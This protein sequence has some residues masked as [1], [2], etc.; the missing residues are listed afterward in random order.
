MNSQSQPVYDPRGAYDGGPYRQP[1]G[2][3]Q[4]PPNFDGGQQQHFDSGLD[5]SRQQLQERVAFLENT[6]HQME[7]RIKEMQNQVWQARNEN[8]QLRN[9]LLWASKR[10][11]EE[12][13]DIQRHLARLS[14]DQAEDAADKPKGKGREKGEKGAGEKGWKEEDG[15]G[16]GRSGKQR[17]QRWTGEQQQQ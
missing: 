11:K 15:G 7:E 1:P 16:K 9:D 13:E 14:A 6:F 8:D 2:A 17:D 4:A 12:I 10:Q 5:Y 3:G